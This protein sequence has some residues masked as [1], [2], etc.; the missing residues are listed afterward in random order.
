MK[1]KIAIVLLSTLAQR[2]VLAGSTSSRLGRIAQDIN[3][4][5]ENEKQTNHL[6][7]MKKVHGGKSNAIQDDETND[8]NDSPSF[9]PGL[10]AL[11][12]EDDSKN[13]NHGTN[14]GAAQRRDSV[15]VCAPSAT[16]SGD[17]LFVFLR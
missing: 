14:K 8:E 7:K 6:R 4:G 15:K 10:R 1:V 2:A 13:W 5:G 11:R 17:T 9:T 3:A 12:G 16:R